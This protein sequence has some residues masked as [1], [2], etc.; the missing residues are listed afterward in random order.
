[1][2]DL[3]Q[4]TLSFDAPAE[5]PDTA[6]KVVS[7]EKAAGKKR[8]RK[9]KPAPLVPKQ[10]S[11]RGRMSLKEIEA[12]ADLIDIPN[13]ETLYQKQYYTIGQVAEMFHVNHSLIR[14]WSNEFDGFLQTRKN[15]KGDRYFRP[16]D[17]KTLEFIHHLLRQRKF[18]TQGARD[19]LKKNK[20][21]DERFSV[22]QSMQKIKG[23][24]LEIKASL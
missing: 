13:D 22:V 23:F 3:K 8:G 12:T 18:T 5:S 16:E 11:K 6:T 9:P 4:I 19:F 1:M 24:L 20:H 17:I 2:E 10:P 7:E 15:K 14:M 21:A